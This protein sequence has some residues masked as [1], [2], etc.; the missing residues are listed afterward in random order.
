MDIDRNKSILVSSDHHANWEALEKLFQLA[1][2]EGIPFVIN[3]DVVGDYN[4]EFLAEKLE[5]KFPY[6]IEEEFFAQEFDMRE[7]RTYEYVERSGGNVDSL[8]HNVSPQH[9]SEARK[10]IEIIMDKFDNPET[11]KRIADIKEKV[12][13]LVDEHKYKLRALDATIIN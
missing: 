1:H 9:K 6:E 3:G 11:L 2:K 10:Q 12:T 7:Y 5:L 13:P 8:L 4:F